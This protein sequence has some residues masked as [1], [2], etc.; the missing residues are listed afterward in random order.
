LQG[1]WYS[2]AAQSSD[3]PVDGLGHTSPEYSTSEDMVLFGNKTGATLI[4][5]GDY[6][7]AVYMCD[8]LT[9]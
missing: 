6:Y 5:P 7:D 8:E 3:E 2:L 4:V 1:F 9:D